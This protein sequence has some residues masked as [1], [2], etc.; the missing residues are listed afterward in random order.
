VSKT[1]VGNIFVEGVT[2]SRDEIELKTGKVLKYSGHIC[3]FFIQCHIK[4]FSEV[5]DK[6]EYSV[7]CNMQVHYSRWEEGSFTCSSQL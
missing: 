4:S 5:F 1:E 7:G 2:L 3:L 6:V